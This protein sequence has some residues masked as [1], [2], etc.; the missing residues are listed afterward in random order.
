MGMAGGP[1]ARVDGTGIGA[2]GTFVVGILGLKVSSA[3]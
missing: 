2:V 3:G 1:Q